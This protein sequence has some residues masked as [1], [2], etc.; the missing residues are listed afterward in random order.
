MK[1]LH[2][3]KSVFLASKVLGNALLNKLYNLVY[4]RY[5]LHCGPDGMGETEGVADTYFC[6]DCIKKIRRITGPVC[7]V[8]H[9][10]F[11]SEAAM[12]HTPEHCCGDCRE[13]PPSFSR[14]I[15]PFYYE[16][17]LATAIQKFKYNKQTYLSDFLV[18]F[19]M[20]DLI[21]LPVDRVIAIPLHPH[22]LRNREFNQS[23]LL[24]KKI[25]N[26]IARPYSID[27][28]IRHR[29]TLPQVGLSG[30][31]REENVKGAFQVLRP[32][33]VKDQSIL[34]VDDVY[35]TG[36]TL[37]E[38]A[39]ALKVGGAKNVIVAAVARTV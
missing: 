29:E 2:N 11:V 31:E 4:P 24:T 33:E 37:R 38:G 15:T 26:L 18:G 8:C 7:S 1:S 25:A 5:C 22:R 20:D 32:H 9:V 6:E 27:A 3:V 35:T 34:L 36:T 21:N 23:L 13:H 19:L 17:P 10:P 14:A 12:S 16:G 39:K 28:L 30:R